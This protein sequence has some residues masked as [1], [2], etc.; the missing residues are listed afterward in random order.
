MTAR[1]L[2]NWRKDKNCTNVAK[3]GST[4]CASALARIP[5]GF[6]LLDCLRDD[7]PDPVSA[8]LDAALERQRMRAEAFAEGVDAGGLL[9]ARRRV[10]R[11]AER[12]R[13]QE[14]SEDDE[15][16]ALEGGQRNTESDLGDDLEGHRGKRKTH[17]GNVLARADAA[18]EPVRVVARVREFGADEVAL[19]ADEA[20]GLEGRWVRVELLY[21]RKVVST[22]QE[23]EGRSA[24]HAP[25]RGGWPSGLRAR[26]SLSE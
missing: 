21:E 16:G 9:L 7:L 10:E 6:S 20:L 5:P 17:V 15:E 18:P 24:R 11:G 4:L 8:G 14:A 23:R 26:S 2:V 22:G 19:G 12:A 1:S 13:P 25:G 3:G